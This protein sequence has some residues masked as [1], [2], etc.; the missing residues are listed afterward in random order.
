MSTSK[1]MPLPTGVLRRGATYYYRRVVPE[2]LRAAYGKREAVISLRTKDPSEARRLGYLKAAEVEAEFAKARKVLAQETQFA[3]APTLD[4]LTHDQLKIIQ[5][6]YHA[7][8]L[9]EDFEER[10]DGFDDPYGPHDGELTEQPRRSWDEKLEVAAHLDTLNRAEYAQGREG[11][12]WPGE[13][14]EVLSWSNVRLKVS[15]G[16]RGWRKAIRALQ[17]AWLTAHQAVQRRNDGEVVETPEGPPEASQETVH[18][19]PNGLP[20][21]SSAVESWLREKDTTWGK[22]AA[23]DHRHWLGR[24]LEVAGDR[25]LSEYTKAD[26]RKFKEVLQRLPSNWTKK[27]GLRGKAID[28]AAKK[29]AELGMPPM[30]TS[31]ANKAIGRVQSFWTWAAANYFDGPSPEPLKGLKFAQRANPRDERHPFNPDQLHKIFSAPIYTGCKSLRSFHEPGPLVPR[32]M[33][34]NAPPGGGKRTSAP[35]YMTLKIFRKLSGV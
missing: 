3:A 18:P 32:A 20:V 28:Q 33:V 15:R 31:N 6:A 4:D 25:P 14:E 7:H 11:V 5:D 2:D 35:T 22:K 34:C 21:L 16:S 24:F 19:N 27:P 23:A 29:A 17:E 26:G 8:I 9:E 1:D 13:V 12:F 30:S 10:L